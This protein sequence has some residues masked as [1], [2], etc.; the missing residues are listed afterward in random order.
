MLN[1]NEL[2]N[3]AAGVKSTRQITN[4]MYMIS[5]SKSRRVKRKMDAVKPFFSE[6]DRVIADIITGGADE[7]ESRFTRRATGAKTGLYFVV[8]GDKGM[9]G[10]YNHNLTNF[11][12]EKLDKNA[13]VLLVAGF[14]GRSKA[15]REGFNVDREFKFSVTEPTL[16]RACDI[17]EIIID[18]FSSGAYSEV[19]LVYTKMESSLKQ[20]PV[21]LPLLPLKPVHFTAGNEDAAKNA[22]VRAF[23]FEPNP[24]EVLESLTPHYLKGIIYAA[25]VESNS[26][27]LQSRMLAMESATKNAG[28][29]ITDL[30][31]QYNRVRQSKITQEISEIVGG[32]VN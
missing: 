19:C 24:A 9:A 2:K 15:A 1:A 22:G 10:G 14:L 11:L 3:R 4:A 23:H 7:S 29:I 12:V 21:M 30:S 20:Y 16:N 27:E 13:S 26:C 6:V 17:T 8:G 5:A 32:A 31:L 25:L 18:K 28:E